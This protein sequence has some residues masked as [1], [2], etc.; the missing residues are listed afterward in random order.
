MLVATGRMAAVVFYRIEP[1]HVAAGALAAMMLGANATD[2]NG[3]A[4]DWSRDD[5]L[6]MVVVGWPRVHG[7]LITAIAE[8]G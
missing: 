3:D 5:E 8:S 4:I 1:M 7:Q 2:G 6:P